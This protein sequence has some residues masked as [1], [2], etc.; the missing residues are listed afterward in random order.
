MQIIKMKMKKKDFEYLVKMLWKHPTGS[1][2][3]GDKWLD[4]EGRLMYTDK[5]LIPAEPIS[6][7]AVDPDKAIELRLH[8]KNFPQV[9]L[10]SGVEWRTE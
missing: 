10:Q 9:D 1:L 7:D 5:A 6:F 3:I 8:S 4:G 2:F